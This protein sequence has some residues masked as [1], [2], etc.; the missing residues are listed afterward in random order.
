MSNPKALQV[1]ERLLDRRFVAAFDR[2]WGFCAPC[3]QSDV[4]LFFG[5]KKRRGKTG[6]TVPVACAVWRFSSWFPK[7]ASI[8]IG[9]S[10][11]NT[12]ML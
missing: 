10:A 5:A 11:Q 9:N 7:C 3:W 1:A 12:N 2:Q 8:G 6:P 4:P